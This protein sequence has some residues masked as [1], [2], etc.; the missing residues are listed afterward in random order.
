MINRQII[1]FKVEWHPL[2]YDI[3]LLE[4]CN[5]NTIQLQGYHSLGG[6]GNSKL[7]MNARLIQIADN[8]HVSTSQILLTWSLQRGV[9]VIPKSI[10]SAHIAEN[11]DLTIRLTSD[12]MLTIDTLVPAPTRLAWNPELVF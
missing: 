3:A 4:Y 10:N 12:E 6:T 11:Y 9:A 8:Y 5:K 1:L 7:R 2:F